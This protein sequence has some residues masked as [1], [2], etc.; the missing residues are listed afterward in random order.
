VRIR[1]VA[2]LTVPIASITARTASTMPGPEVPPATAIRV[3]ARSGPTN[4]LALSI[5]PLPAYALDNSSGVRAS[6]GSSEACVGR[7]SVIDQP[8]AVPARYTSGDGAWV[9][10]AIAATV[11]VAASRP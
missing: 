11:I 9:R 5:S 7:I 8:A 2:T 3:P 6:R 4:A 1:I 10:S